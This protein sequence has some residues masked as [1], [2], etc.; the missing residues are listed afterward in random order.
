MSRNGQTYAEKLRRPEWQRKRLEILERDGFKCTDCG[1]DKSELHVHHLYYTKGKQPWEYEDDAYRTLC[2]KCHEAHENMKVLVLTA[3]GQLD[4]K[5][6][7]AIYRVI[8]RLSEKDQFERGTF[9]LVV[10]ETSGGDIAAV[11]GM[12]FATRVACDAIAAER[13]R[14]GGEE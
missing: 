7:Y 11:N 10:K 1:D 5:E 14:Y 2:A 6:T 4:W 13:N 3:M 9:A 8:R 12:L